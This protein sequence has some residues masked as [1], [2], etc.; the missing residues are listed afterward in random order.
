MAISKDP[1]SLIANTNNVQPFSVRCSQVNK[2]SFLISYLFMISWIIKFNVHIYEVKLVLLLITIR[3][4][5]RNSNLI[6]VSFYIGTKYI[7]YFVFFPGALSLCNFIYNE[8]DFFFFLIIIIT[9]YWSHES[10]SMSSFPIF[11]N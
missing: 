11:S 9:N 3:N 5:I 10:F 2:V 4:Y 8:V 1:F 7:N 6:F